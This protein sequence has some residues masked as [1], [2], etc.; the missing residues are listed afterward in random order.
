MLRYFPRTTQSPS[1]EPLP[2]LLGSVSQDVPLVLTS[3]SPSVSTTDMPSNLASQ[4][5]VSQFLLHEGNYPKNKRKYTE[6]K[7]FASKTKELTGL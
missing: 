7:K 1:S 4:A 3:Q 6:Q 5:E 2:G